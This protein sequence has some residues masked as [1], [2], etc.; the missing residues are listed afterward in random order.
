MS[1]YVSNK[2]LNKADIPIAYTVQDE[3]KEFV[4]VNYDED[5]KR[6]D[7]IKQLKIDKGKF[8]YY[9]YVEQNQRLAFFISGISGSGKSTIAR[10]L[11]DQMRN[12]KKFKNYRI[13]FLSNKNPE[14]LDPAF[15][16]LKNF[17]AIDIN[18]QDFFNISWEDFKNCFVIFD[19]FNTMYKKDPLYIFIMLLNKQLLEMGRKHNTHIITINHQSQNYN[20]TRNIIFESNIY[21]LFPMTNLN[22]T[23]KFLRSYLDYDKIQLENLKKLKGG[24]FS[25]LIISKCCP[26]FQISDKEI[27]LL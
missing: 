17:L 18:N 14:N 12:D 1:L 26:Q 10:Y 8:H 24:K 27:I 16:G 15:H 11:V 6:E 19:D 3:K 5:R 23:Q 13:V 25:P 4:F 7:E 21:I 22:A 2:K 20:E 9:P